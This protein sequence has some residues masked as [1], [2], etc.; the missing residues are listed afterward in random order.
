[1]PARGGSIAGGG[2]SSTMDMTRRGALGALGGALGVLG[3]V[4]NG[5]KADDGT[6]AQLAQAGHVDHKLQAPGFYRQRVGERVIT[7]ISDGL[8]NWPVGVA[9]TDV[10]DAQLKAL[11]RE[12][13]LDTE[14]VAA[15][16]NACVVETA[17]ARI[18]I[19]AGAG[20]D[21]Q[22]SSGRLLQNLAAAGYK[23]E[24]IDLVVVTHCHLDHIGGLVDPF[25]NT[26]VFPRADYVMLGAEWD[27]WTGEQAR[28]TL[29]EPW[30][31]TIDKV[32]AILLA[33]SARVRRL[34][35]PG[36][37]APGIS[38]F[39]T[40]GTTPGHASVLVDGGAEKL[41]IAGNALA[42]AVVAFERPDWR[43]GLDLDAEM[44]KNTRLA[45][46]ERCANEA[47]LVLG[48]HLPYPG[49]GRVGRRGRTYRWVPSL[50]TWEV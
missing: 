35:E 1:M 45:L 23:T 15:H 7:V 38:L 8:V 46:L 29:K 12:S 22:P 20:A 44:A 21:Y 13:F 49:L 18:L 6:S 24:D 19:D 9:A 27:F 32:Q 25:A 37:V 2:R 14:T 28:A 33:I 17:D 42:H 34:T 39:T 48:Y 41:I 3:G 31:A 47:P 30:S 11:L 43:S 16:L 5:A 36:E 40:G 10:P 4:A 26:P 50:W